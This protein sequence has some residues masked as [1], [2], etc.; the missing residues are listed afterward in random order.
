MDDKKKK[1]LNKLE[2]L[3]KYFETK[4]R[5]ATYIKVARQKNKR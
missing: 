1:L 5:I 2:S 3:K 4:R